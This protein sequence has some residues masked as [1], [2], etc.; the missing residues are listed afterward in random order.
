PTCDSR[1]LRDASQLD[2]IDDGLEIVALR[3]ASGES[4]T[5]DDI[6]LVINGRRHSESVG[7]EPPT[8]WNKLRGEIGEYSSIDAVGKRYRVEAVA[9]GI[10]R[11]A[12]RHI[13]KRTRIEVELKPIAI[14]QWGCSKTDTQTWIGDVAITKSS[15]NQGAGNGAGNN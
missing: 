9:L 13:G 3:R 8:G 4:Q 12:Q 14:V 6:C 11:K 15:I 1:W 10:N 7:V 2:V 5:Q